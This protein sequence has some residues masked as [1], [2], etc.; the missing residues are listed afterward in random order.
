M[1]FLFIISLFFIILLSVIV[2]FY[3]CFKSRKKSVIPLALTW[4]FFL[5]LYFVFGF[6]NGIFN[7]SILEIISVIAV[8][9]VVSVIPALIILI[10]RK[11]VSA[12]HIL[13]EFAFSVSF[14]IGILLF[15][16]CSSILSYYVSSLLILI[17]DF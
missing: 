11:Q 4:I 12:K 1:V 3:A 5:F 17:F 13:I 2:S 15:L 8:I 14:S 9:S 16:Y 7:Y 6:K 10:A